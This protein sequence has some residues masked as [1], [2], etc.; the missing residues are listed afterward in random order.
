M[1]DLLYRE[2]VI[3]DILQGEWSGVLYRKLADFLVRVRL[4]NA[5]QKWS[6]M[7]STQ[8]HHRFRHITPTSTTSISSASSKKTT[9][10]PKIPPQRTPLPLIHHHHHPKFCPLPLP[11][12]PTNFNLSNVRIPPYNAP[13]PSLL[14]PPLSV[15]P[16]LV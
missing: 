6:F 14:G 10:T 4:D 15:P 8:S 12:Q 5:L 11:Q 9:H 3:Y 2:F 16:L 13:S 1:G 7:P